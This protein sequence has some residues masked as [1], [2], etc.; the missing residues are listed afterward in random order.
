MFISFLFKEQMFCFL[1]RIKHLF[2]FVNVYFYYIYFMSNK[3]P[4][5]STPYL[6][7]CP[8]NRLKFWRM[9]ELPIIRDR[10]TCPR[11]VPQQDIK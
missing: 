8:D 9:P 1:F 11:I 4:L 6:L 10:K 2:V 7:I 3:T 5:K